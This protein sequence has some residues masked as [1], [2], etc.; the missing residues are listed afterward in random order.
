MDFINVMIQMYHHFDSSIQQSINV[1][2]NRIILFKL[3][4]MTNFKQLKHLSFI[5]LVFVLVLQSC[6]T[7]ETATIGFYNVENLFDTKDNPNKIDEQFLPE[8]DY[9]WDETRYSNK[10]DHLADVIAKMSK[11]ESP[12][13]LGLCEVENRE[14]LEDLVNQKLLKSSGYSIV[15]FE[16]PDA[17]GIDVALLY[18]SDLFKKKSANKVK[19]DLA[20]YGEN[21]RDVLYVEL[22]TKG[23][24]KETIHLIVNHWPSRRE[25]KAKSEPKRMLA[26]KTARG[27]KDEIV[28]KDPEAC[29]IIMGDFNDEPFDKSILEV[30]N[31]TESFDQVSR[32][33]MYNPMA[34]LK[35]AGLG[36]YNFRGNWNMLDQIIVSEALLD[37]KGL[38]YEKHSADIF[39]PD[40]MRQHGGKYDQY[41]NRTFGGRKY[42]NGYSDHFPVSIQ[43]KFVA[44]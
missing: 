3:P 4:T 16:S 9:K 11:G 15:H 22:Q 30:V 19:L 25:G 18:K 35:Q 14:V 36:S 13:I 29:I 40:W 43:V 23:K 5:I 44:H 42:L 32:E 38:E 12:D 41:P 34:R 10:L 24:N 17:R 21:S 31:T 37:G 26:A 8:G 2:E 6:K 1:R 20:E 39:S 7:T 27:I 28:A 33:K